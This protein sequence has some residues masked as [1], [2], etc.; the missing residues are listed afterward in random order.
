M[1]IGVEVVENEPASKCEYLTL[2]L[3]GGN[4]V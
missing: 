4:G 3:R 1:K 2:E